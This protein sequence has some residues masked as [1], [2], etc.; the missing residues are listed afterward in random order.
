LEAVGDREGDLDRLLIDAH[1]HRVRD[2]GR[3]QARHGVR[4][5]PQR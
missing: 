5:A 2:D 4:V 1:V 3:A